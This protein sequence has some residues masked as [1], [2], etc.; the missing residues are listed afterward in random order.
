M[1]ANGNAS[2]KETKLGIAAK[3]SEDMAAWYTQVLLKAEMM[4]YHDVSGCYILRPWSFKVWKCIQSK[5][6]I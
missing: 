3:K 2:K 5:L 6:E 4:D 1:S